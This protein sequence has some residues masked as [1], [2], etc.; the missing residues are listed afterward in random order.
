MMK[1]QKNELP[2]FLYLE[3][4]KEQ[5]TL[6]ISTLELLDD[7]SCDT[8][9]DMDTIF[10]LHQNVGT[11]CIDIVGD[12]NRQDSGVCGVNVEN[13]RGRQLVGT[14]EIRWIRHYCSSQRM[15]LVGE[16]DFSFSTSLA[17]A[18][19]SAT[20]MIATSFDSRG[21]KYVFLM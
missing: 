12:N 19:G 2:D 3:D 1:Q 15:L 21:N 11:T 16:G 14:G 7:L 4:P 6:L 9:S 13:L 5:C 20:N 8:E 10:R 18:F 17:R